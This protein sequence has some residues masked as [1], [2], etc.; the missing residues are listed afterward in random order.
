[1]PNY[2]A[3]NP[4]ATSPTVSSTAKPWFDLRNASWLS[5][6][7]HALAGLSLLTILSH[8]LQ[9][10]G[11]LKYRIEFIAHNASI[12]VGGWC[13][14]NVAA[15]SILYFFLCLSRAWESEDKDSHRLLKLSIFLATAAVAIDLSAEAI[16][17]GLTGYFANGLYTIATILACWSTRNCYP[18]V[19][20]LFGLLVGIS[21]LALSY[22]SLADS[23]SGLFWSNVVLVPSLLFWQ[24][25]IALASDRRGRS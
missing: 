14:W 21:G 1:M 25:G 24:A 4:F 8:G 6:F 5:V 23:T 13:I 2:S 19:I 17:V 12:W 20:V 3:K 18:K 10:N 9:T 7:I 15:L 11:D 22:F 16:A